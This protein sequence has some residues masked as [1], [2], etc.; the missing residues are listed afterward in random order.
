MVGGG[1][2]LVGRSHECDF[3]AAAV[4]GVPMLTAQRTTFTTPSEVDTQVR[5]ALSSGT[6][7]YTIDEAK[8]RELKPTVIVT[9]SLCSVCSIDVSEVRAVVE[10]MDPQPT[11]VCLN[12]HTLQEM[13]ESLTLVGDALG[14]QSQALIATD[15]LQRRINA[16]VN[17]PRSN[18]SISSSGNG[19]IETST[20]VTVSSENR[21]AAL[22]HRVAFMEWTDPIYV[23]GHWT[24]ELISLAG[25]VH[26]LNLT[27]GSKSFAVTKQAF[28]DSNP[29]IILVAP[30]GLDLETTESLV[31]DLYNDENDLWFREMPAVKE[32]RVV[33]V[34]GNQMFNRPGP[35]LVDCLE[36]LDWCLNTPVSGWANP[37]E[38][39]ADFPFKIFEQPTDKDGKSYSTST[40]S[41]S[42]SD[43]PVV[44]VEDAQVSLLSP[45]IVE[46]HRIA[47]DACKATYKDPSTGYSVFTEYSIAKRGFCCGRGCRHCTYGHVMVPEA[48]GR[49]NKISQ[50]VLMRFKPK[51]RRKR[52]KSIE[53]DSGSDSSGS[54]DKQEEELKPTKQVK[55]ISWSG[56]KDS[57]LAW[58]A[59]VT[60]Q[61]TNP[62]PNQHVVLMTTFQR[63]DNMVPEQKIPVS[64]IV[65]QAK[66][67]GVDLLLVP[68]PDACP[69]AAYLE[70][71]DSGLTRLCLD[72]ELSS[73]EDVTVVYGDLH[74]ED[75]RAWR[76]SNIAGL[77]V[78]CE[79]PLFNVPYTELADRL[80]GPA[81]DSTA[82]VVVGARGP[83]QTSFRVSNVTLSEL[84]EELSGLSVDA[85]YNRAMFGLLN[86][87]EAVDAF[88]ECGEFH[89]HAII[90]AVS[91]QEKPKTN[92]DW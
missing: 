14:L 31:H 87:S 79:F 28:V 84:S 76:E 32:G 60:N 36:W 3:P 51:Q 78:K 12:P 77:G 75:I 92:V 70:Q 38:A 11:I 26:T 63:S 29:D 22:H 88:G 33:L 20:D 4:R 71:V 61:D 18:G 7:L 85:E 19:S 73:R 47:C 39:I 41:T 6:S 42:C 16:V 91:E 74:L 83:V 82:H 86:E 54:S 17:N 27:V 46:A 50:P 49:T 35:R 72:Y 21:A 10:T 67:L 66:A 58:H 9:Q 30:C 90:E 15:S 37:P 1:R 81:D 53:S 23:G 80:L 34:D 52:N 65:A 68:L 56:G 45:E 62:D 59:V 13:V 25:G 8:L 48:A 5:E 44:D 40:F 55:L 24:P 64:S 69:N 43:K 2:Y 57:F 89:T